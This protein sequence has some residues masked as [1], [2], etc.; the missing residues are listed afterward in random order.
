MRLN[1]AILE[2]DSRLKKA[3]KIRAIIENRMPIQ[4]A[5]VL[6][7]GTGSGVAASTLAKLVGS[8][9]SVRATDVKDQRIVQDGFEFQLVN[10][11]ALPF[12]DQTFDLVISNHVIEHVGDKE[13]QANHLREIR[14]VLKSNGFLYL[15]VPNKW[16]LIEPH[17]RIPFLSW[18]PKTISDFVVKL[19][20]K[21]NEYDCLPPSRKGLGRL[22]YDAA[23]SI[24][25]IDREALA[26]VAEI[27]GSKLAYV[28]S[29]L[30]PQILSVFVVVTPTFIVIGKK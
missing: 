13:D 23:L 14:R 18:F 20:G 15:A 27:E 10:D 25:F 21:N 26:A 4:G 1:H 9:G 8:S 22:F 6:E 7:V 30:P 2:S 3:E 11:T 17:Y 16:R 5:R 24:E 28:L 12:P 19:S 29:K